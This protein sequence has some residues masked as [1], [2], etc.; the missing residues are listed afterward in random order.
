[1]ILIYLEIGT[2]PLDTAP[3]NESRVQVETSLFLSISL[4]SI[5]KKW[6]DYLKI[7]NLATMDSHSI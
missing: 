7:M 6:V 1:M 3:V 2:S 4:T 5:A